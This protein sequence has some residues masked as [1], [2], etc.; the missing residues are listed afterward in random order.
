ML[1]LIHKVNCFTINI[2]W[3]NSSCIKCS[4]FR[5]LVWKHLQ[6]CLLSE[7]HGSFTVLESELRLVL[8]FVEITWV[9]ATHLSKIGPMTW[10]F[11]SQI[12]FLCFNCWSINTSPWYKLL[13]LCDNNLP[14]ASSGNHFG[15]NLENILDD[16]KHNIRVK[17]AQYNPRIMT[18]PN[19]S[20]FAILS[21]SFIWTVSTTPDTLALI[22]ST[23]SPGTG[24][25]TLGTLQLQSCSISTMIHQ[26]LHSASLQQNPSENILM[27]RFL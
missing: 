5:A 26:I 24:S 21:L 11:H 20:T 25:A 2:D 17:R 22:C 6:F 8:D 12:V 4:H 19:S 18:W 13:Q 15:N 3:R 23:S 16:M 14:W 27:N 1:S 10:P 9:L 7:L